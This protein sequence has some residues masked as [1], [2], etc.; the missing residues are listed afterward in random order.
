MG[1]QERYAAACDGHLPTKLSTHVTHMSIFHMCNHIH[2][3]IHIYLYM[4]INIHDR[5]ND[6]YKQIYIY[7]YIHGHVSINVDSETPGNNTWIVRFFPPSDDA[8]FSRSRR[9]FLCS[10]EWHQGRTGIKKNQQMSVLAPG[11]VKK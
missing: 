3:H 11:V 10:A 1:D 2:I 4:Y 9:G 7:I 8:R 6:I 5:Y